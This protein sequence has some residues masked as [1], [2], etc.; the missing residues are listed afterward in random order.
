MLSKKQH[1]HTKPKATES[2]GIGRI[3][4]SIAYIRS[5]A[6]WQNAVAAAVAGPQPCGFYSLVDLVEAATNVATA[7]KWVEFLS[8]IET[9]NAEIVAEGEKKGASGYE[10]AN[11][12]TFVDYVRQARK[13]AEEHVK[14]F[15]S[16]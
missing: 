5:L 7:Q 12:R 16:R 4:T 9:A 14:S 11:L 13:H 3:E 6:A 15:S 8:D 10:L 2:A 1:A